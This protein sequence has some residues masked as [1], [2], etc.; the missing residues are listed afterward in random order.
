MVSIRKVSQEAAPVSLKERAYRIIRENIINLRFLPGSMLNEKDLVAQVG[1]SRTPIREA[2]SR[3]EQEQLVVIL[4]QRGSFVAEI[5]AKTI[6]DVYQ[7]REMLEPEL[8]RLVM[9]VIVEESL[10][11]FRKRFVTSADD[12]YDAATT[13]DNDFHNFVLRSCN[14]DYLLQMMGTLYAQ[15]ERIRI[16]MIRAPLRLQASAY[17]HLAIIDAMLDRDAGR[18]VEAMRV[19][20]ANARRSAIN[21][22]LGIYD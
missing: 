6:N 11:A 2:L 16:L 14:N 13:A 21:F 12:D 15:N 17:E 9:P 19:H 7:V 4:P 18:A 5:T 10:L 22:Q 8:V 3:L 1:A 20:M